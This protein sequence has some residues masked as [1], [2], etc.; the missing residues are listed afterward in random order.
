MIISSTTSLM[1]GASAY[2]L[3]FS[4]HR[5][6]VAFR[7][8]NRMHCGGEFVITELEIPMHFFIY[9]TLYRNFAA[10]W[11]LKCVGG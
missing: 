4:A 2:E 7:I 9:H 10:L 1:T 11:T 6:I 8:I 5:I 3:K